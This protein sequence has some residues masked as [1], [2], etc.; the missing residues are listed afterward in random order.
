[1]LLLDA[2]TPRLSPFYKNVIVL[3]TTDS[4]NDFIKKPDYYEVGN[5]VLSKY[6]SKGKGTQGNSFYCEKNKG[7]Y[8][9]FVIDTNQINH[10]INLIPLMMGIAIARSMMKYQIAIQLKWVNDVLI[11]D[12]KVAGIL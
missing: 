11:D 7:I 5:I 3:E 6:Q 4:T 10:M 8:A 2:I 1:M 12:K 9:S